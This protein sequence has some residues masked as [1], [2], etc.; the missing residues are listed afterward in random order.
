[1]YPVKIGVCIRDTNTEERKLPC[2]GFLILFY[3][4][5]KL[6]HSTVSVISISRL[7]QMPQQ[8]TL[9]ESV[10]GLPSKHQP[11]GSMKPG[12]NRNSLRSSLYT[13]DLQKYITWWEALAQ[14]CIILIVH[15]T[16]NVNHDQDSSTSDQDQ[17]IQRR[18]PTSVTVFPLL[19]F[20]PRSSNWFR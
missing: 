11:F 7:Q 12:P 14:L 9:W 20:S 13:K 17:T 15:L 16:T 2:F 19:K 10:G 5:S 3:H 8:M 18:R 1:M 6:Y 4:Y